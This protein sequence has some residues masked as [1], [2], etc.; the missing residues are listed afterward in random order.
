[1]PPT[2]PEPRVLLTGCCQT[3]KEWYIEN[4]FD[5]LLWAASKVS[6]SCPAEFKV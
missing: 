4:G 2:L 6:L 3:A 1:M 5:Q